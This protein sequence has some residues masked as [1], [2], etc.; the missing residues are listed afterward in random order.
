MATLRAIQ[1]HIIFQFED[2][3]VMVS[4]KR[5][6]RERHGALYLPPNRELSINSPRWVVVRGIGPLVDLDIKPGY[7]ILIEPLKWTKGVRF[8]S[9]EFWKTLPAHVMMIDEPDL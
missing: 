3:S 4:G 7:R 6:F 5:V 2:E 1:D 9:E 8:Q